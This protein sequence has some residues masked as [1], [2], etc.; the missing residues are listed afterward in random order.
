MFVKFSSL[1]G[2]RK[3][4]RGRGGEKG[5]RE[6]SLPLSPIP[7]PFFPSSLSPIPY[8]FRRLLRRLWNFATLWSNI[9]EVKYR[10]YVNRQ[11]RICTTGP[12]FPFTC[13]L[14]FIISTHKLVVSR[15]F[16]SIRIVLSCFYLLIFYFEKFST[17]IC[18]IGDGYLSIF[19]QF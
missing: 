19:A 16:L 12:S 11:T 3:K 2:R 10:V 9:I 14:L 18:R 15:N 17:W 8:P 5:K 4:G 6:G 7:L 1:R 13:R